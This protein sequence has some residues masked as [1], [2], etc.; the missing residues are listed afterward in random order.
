M[1]QGPVT[2]YCHTNTFHRQSLLSSPLCCGATV[3]VILGMYV[4]VGCLSGGRES[5]NQLAQVGPHVFLC[6]TDSRGEAIHEHIVGILGFEVC[7]EEGVRL[8][9]YLGQHLFDILFRMVT[10]K[11]LY[12]RLPFFDVRR[13]P[14]E[15]RSKVD[16]NNVS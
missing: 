4:H 13:R 12:D 2:F 8:A 7:K 16:T 5:T 1:T 6:D 3:D 10:S 11:V 15:Q 9:S 14:N